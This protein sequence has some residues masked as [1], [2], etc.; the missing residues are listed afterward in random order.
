MEKS[1]NKKLGP[2]TDF[3]TSDPE[4]CVKI[5]CDNENEEFV[6]IPEVF[7]QTA[8]LY[9]DRPALVYEDKL[10]GKLIEISFKE[11]LRKVEH[12]AKV[13]LKLGLERKGRV[14]VL[15]FNSSESVVSALAANFAG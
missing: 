11:Y 13:F 3:S 10:S 2:A 5:L 14:A 1:Q 12:M 9:P 4:K 6:T 8:N 7:K 15:A